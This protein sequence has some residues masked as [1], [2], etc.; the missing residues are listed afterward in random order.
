MKLHS[1]LRFAPAT[2]T[3]VD[4]RSFLQKIMPGPPRLRR[5]S[6]TQEPATGE[7]KVWVLQDGAP[8]EVSVAVGPTDGK[9]TQILR[10]NLEPGQDVI[11]DS[12]AIK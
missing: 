11:V 3:A 5:P 8:R 12:A 6:A 1:R 7:R 9:R 2:E 4:Q 10:G